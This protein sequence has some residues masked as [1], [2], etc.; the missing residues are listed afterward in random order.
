MAWVGVL[1]RTIK[2]VDAKCVQVAD[3]L[4]CLWSDR[5][6]NRKHRDRFLAGHQYDSGLGL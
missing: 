2:H 6:S 4:R 1:I 3:R 5:V